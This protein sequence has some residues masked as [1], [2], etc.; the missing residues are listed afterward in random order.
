MLETSSLH[1]LAARTIRRMIELQTDASQQQCPI[2]IV[3][4]DSWE[5]PQGVGLYGLFKRYEQSGDASLLDYMKGWYE[6]RMGAGLPERNVNTTAPM[7]CLA[8]L[9][10]ATGNAQ[11]LGICD[12]WAEW[13]M[14]GMART[15]DGGIQHDTT[16]HSNAGQIWADTLYMTVLFLAKMGML[17]RRADYVEEAVQQFL[18]HIKYLFDRGTGLWFH[19]WTFAN[20]TNFANARWARGNCWFTAGVVDFLEMVNPP[21]GTRGYLISTLRAQAEALE[22]N[23]ARGGLWH[24][25]LDDPGSYE[26]ASATAGFGYGILK[27]VRMGYL[28][29]RFRECGRRALEA[30]VRNI[31]PDGTLR[32]VSFGTPMGLDLDH[33]RKIPVCPMPYGQALAVLLLGEALRGISSSS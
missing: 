26:E 31:T 23:Q 15:A 22:R 10:E 25:L 27:G 17:R 13:V 20:R 12:D 5:W 28:P 33:Y 3:A 7:L 30:V 21:A 24:T 8:H 2:D 4:F 16:G 18:I 32:N 6:R 19:G 1:D 9:C 29:A 11:W 14:H